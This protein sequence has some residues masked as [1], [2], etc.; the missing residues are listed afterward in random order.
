MQEIADHTLRFNR[1]NRPE[2]NFFAAD[3]G[4]FGARQ[5]TGLNFAQLS[6]EALRAK[7]EE[8]KE[9]FRG[10][11]LEAY[12]RDAPQDTAWCKRMLSTLFLDGNEDQ[13]E[14]VLSGLSPE[15]ALHVES[16]PGGRFEEGEFLIDPIFDEADAHPEDASLQRLCDP[17]AAGIIFNHIREYV[18]VEYINVG[19]IPESL[20]RNRPTNKG[21]RGVYL[22]EFKPRSEAQP[23]KRFIRFQKFDT[24]HHLDKGVDLFMAIERSEEYTDYWLDRR[25]GC[26]QLGMNLTHRVIMRRLTEVYNGT[27]APY[28]GKEIRTTYFEREYLPGIA[29]DKLEGEKLARPEY[30]ARLA[31]LLGQAATPSLIVGRALD[32]GKVPVFDDGDEVVCEDDNGLPSEILVGDHSGAFGEYKDAI[33]KFAAHYAKP[34]NARARYLTN[35][36]E[37]AETYLAAFRARFTRMQEDYRKRRR[38][39]DKL[40]KRYRYDE[41]GSF[42]YRWV[43]VLKRLDGADVDA[44]VGSIRKNITCL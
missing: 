35:P 24:W 37:F 25:L 43:C 32:S 27:N 5:F 14:Q 28:R 18:D 3:W 22:V 19:R 9:Q 17:R 23:I 31:N 20:A 7:Y 12:R 21:R 29:S 16:L 4:R 42:A 11:V 2:V 8:L 39:F 10:A 6:P 34:V 13:V 30:A 15:F 44:V 33:D 41:G 36:R 1:L 38:A 40:F 26:R